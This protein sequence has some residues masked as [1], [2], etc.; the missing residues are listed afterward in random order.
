MD[1]DIRVVDDTAL[2]AGHEWM[3][4]Q[5]RGRVALVIAR[6]AH[7][8]QAMAEGWAAYRRLE[9]QPLYRR[10]ERQALAVPVPRALRVVG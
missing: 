8:P 4:L 7:G 6:S 1:Y 3:L 9:R 5:Y 10:L 2:P